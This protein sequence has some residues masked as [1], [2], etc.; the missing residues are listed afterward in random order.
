M[1]WVLFQVLGTRHPCSHGTSSLGEKRQEKKINK[2]IS[3]HIQGLKTIKEGLT[4]WP[5]G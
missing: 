5:N 2:V 1:W 4:P 3:D